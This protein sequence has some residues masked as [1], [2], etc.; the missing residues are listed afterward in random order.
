[1][2]E[3]CLR[4]IGW[5][6]TEEYAKAVEELRSMLVSK[7]PFQPQPGKQP[8][9][10]AKMD[11]SGKRGMLVD[12]GNLFRF[13]ADEGWVPNDC[14]RCRT[15]AP[16][17][18]KSAW[19][20]WRKC[21]GCALRDRRDHVDA[22][23]RVGFPPQAKRGGALDEDL[24]AAIH[25]SMELALLGNSAEIADKQQRQAQLKRISTSLKHL[26]SEVRMAFSCEPNVTAVAGD[27]HAV[28]AA[29]LVD[30]MDHPDK[31]LPFAMLHGM[32]VVGHI[33]STGQFRPV[34]LSA[35]EV[36]QIDSDREEFEETA[37]QWTEDLATRLS[38]EGNGASGMTLERLTT[39]E[40]LTRAE[41]DT[42]MMTKVGDIEAL[43][44][45]FPR[46][47]VRALRRFMAPQEGKPQGR[48]CD[49]GKSSGHN[50]ATQLDESYIPSGP[51]II[52]SIAAE[53]LAWWKRRGFVRSGLDAIAA[54]NRILMTM[55]TEDMKA[56][57]RK[58]PTSQPHYTVVG[59][60][61]VIEQRPIFFIVN[62]LPFGLSSAVN[63]FNRLPHFIQAVA[64]RLLGIWAVHYFD[65]WAVPELAIAKGVGQRSLQSLHLMLG[66]ALEKKKRQQSSVRACYLGMLIDLS[67]AIDG[68]VIFSPKHTRCTK[69]LSRLA[70]AKEEGK[71]NST[72]SGGV[73]GKVAWIGQGLM[74]RAGRFATQAFYERQHA[75]GVEAWT[76][77]LEGSR[78][79]LVDLFDLA[80]WEFLGGNED[81]P[82]C[83]SAP[84]HLCRQVRV[85]GE[86]G[87]Y[88]S[89]WSD[90]SLESGASGLGVAMV[91][92][93]CSPPLRLYAASECPDWLMEDLRAC[94][95]TGRRRDKIICQLEGLAAVAAQM[96]FA[97]HLQGRRFLSFIDNTAALSCII[98]GVS[99]KE[100]M[101]RIA[102][103][104]QLMVIRGGADGWHEHVRSRS[105]IADIPSRLDEA[106]AEQLAEMGFAKVDM[107]LPHR[108]LWEDLRVLLHGPAGPED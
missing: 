2:D 104:Y 68:I 30:A 19:S 28:F 4:R 47:P 9:G 18:D 7:S 76:T 15:A 79:F 24:L 92:H 81:D 42:N 66:V 33:P 29:A 86:D 1:M 105:N 39:I 65:D 59:I 32:D 101:G 38:L 53:V 21:E 93:S 14:D 74:A 8:G 3:S 71:L 98:N 70:R 78:L 73:A 89:L 94:P 57:Y 60:W 96:T 26:N 10:L 75:P 51:E 99:N 46:L 107:V 80:S 27:F 108:E 17:E 97:K 83:W 56:A 84:A 23:A 43:S 77:L 6:P 20:R 100:D 45:R 13:M 95:S 55:G 103:M 31:M 88:L 25:H 16:K 41:C 22:A 85:D 72:D 36:A 91:D 34:H 64:R 40:D 37:W 12:E 69:V 61:S 5:E 49:D 106:S 50:A 44:R 48:Q 67:R 62:G 52:A 58:V 63:Q 54:A 87:S 35:E 102:S 90:A 11:D 82:L